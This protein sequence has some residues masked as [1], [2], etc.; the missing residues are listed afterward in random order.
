[1]NSS[2]Q[3]PLPLLIDLSR[4]SKAGEVLFLPL[5]LRGA[6]APSLLNELDGGESPS[7]T[8]QDVEI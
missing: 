7:Q 1:M 6:L 4:G 8:S 3:I 5:P 2:P